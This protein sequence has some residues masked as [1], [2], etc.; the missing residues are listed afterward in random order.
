MLDGGLLKD[1]IKE[2]LFSGMCTLLETANPETLVDRY[3]EYRDD[4]VGFCEEVFQEQYTDD[5][6]R[7]MESVRDYELTIAMSANGTGKTHLASRLA[8]WFYL[9]RTEVTIYT[10]A[11]PPED[12][13]ITILWGEIGEALA[14]APHVVEGSKVKTLDIARAPKQFIRGVAIP[15][16]GDAKR[17]EAK[18]S[19]KH[20][21]HLMFIFDEGDAIP[22]EVYAGRE[23]CT[24][25]GEFRTL[26]MLNPRQPKGEVYR[27]VTSRA[28]NVVHLSA[29]RHPNVIT[30]ED[31]IPGAVDRNTTVRR[32]HQMCRLMPPEE[33]VPPGAS[34]FVLPP[35][36]IGAVGYDQK[37]QELPPLRA[38]RYKVM[39]PS[40]S[41]MVLGEYP[42]EPED[43]LISEEWIAMARSRWDMYVMRNGEKVP[44][45]VR[46]IAGLDPGEFGADATAWIERYGGWVPMPDE[47]HGVDI[48]ITSD[49]ARDRFRGKPLRCVNVDANGVGAGVAPAL[50]RYGVP[51]QAIKT[52]ETKFKDENYFEE[53]ELGEFR[54]YRDCL[55]WQLREWLRADAGA[56][57]P[58]DEEL[59][60]ELRIPTYSIRGKYIQVMT[61]DVMK[62]ELK[63]S[64]NKFDALSLTFGRPLDIEMANEMTASQA[65]GA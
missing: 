13:L 43:Q 56:M 4:P 47:W 12:N 24:S 61:K 17:R 20:A 7:V 39:I 49:N 30:G 9:T 11:A 38:G 50:M 35:F 65:C 34:T 57:L 8:L 51:A 58:P 46:G 14:K 45:G 23:S 54:I 53:E 26:I 2:E 18:F 6:K 40:F 15:V 59:L 27:M 1:S 32:I 28:A 10:A 16:S 22:D 19:G 21:P 64:P 36:L 33:E 25:G 31:V 48:V 3:A 29:F 52:Q 44:K 60:E 42:A 62:Q 55:A 63:R 41:H 5:A 37:R